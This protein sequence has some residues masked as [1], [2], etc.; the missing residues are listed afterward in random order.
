MIK[1]FFIGLGAIVFV[2]IGVLLL[3]GLYEES[4]TPPLPPPVKKISVYVS[5]Q[6]K[7]ISVVE[8]E[9][10]GNLRVVDAVNKAG[11]LTDLADAEFVNMAETITDG[12]HIHIPTKEIFLQ[13]VVQNDSFNVTATPNPKSDLVNINTADVSGLS[14]LKGIGPALAQRIIDYREQNGGFKTVDEIKKVRGIGE[15]KFADIKDKITV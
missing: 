10:N 5:G 11:G 8:L 12:Q 7:N 6:I 4:N 13:P 14:T 15:K 2:I 1:K 9:D 3:I